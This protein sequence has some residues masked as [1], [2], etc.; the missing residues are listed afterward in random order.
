MKKYEEPKMELFELD[1]I[2]TGI[3]TQSMDDETVA[4]GGGF[5]PIIG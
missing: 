4:G 5:G 2:I 3:G 1:E